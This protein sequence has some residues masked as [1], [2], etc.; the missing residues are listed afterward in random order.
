M[1][2]EWRKST[3]RS[4]LATRKVGTLSEARSVLKVSREALSGQIC[5]VVCLVNNKTPS[6][7]VFLQLRILKELGAEIMELRILKD[8]ARGMEK[9]RID[10]K[11]VSGERN[12]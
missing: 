7:W 9:R 10:F 4:G 8:L 6:P 1:V 12:S 3:A 2:G 5:F 11:G